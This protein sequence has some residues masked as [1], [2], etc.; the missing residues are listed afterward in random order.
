[1]YTHMSFV[2][3]IIHLI[4]VRATFPVQKY[5]TNKFEHMRLFSSAET[6]TYAHTYIHTHNN[7]N[8]KNIIGH[9]CVYLCPKRGKNERS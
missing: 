9:A 3:S 7:N 5:E 2:Q 4:K 8:N 6:H 1:M